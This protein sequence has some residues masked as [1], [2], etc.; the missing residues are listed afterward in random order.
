[1]RNI[2]RIAV[3]V[4]FLA[5]LLCPAAFLAGQSVNARIYGNVQNEEGEYLAGVWVRALNI[6][7]NA[8]TTAFTSAEKGAFRFPALAP[9]VYQVS[10]DM[11]GYQSYVA[12]GIRLTAD[13]SST[14][15]VK[16]KHLKDSDAVLPVSIPPRPQAAPAEQP[17]GRL[18]KWQ[19][20]LSAGTL[21]GEPAELNDFIA[22]DVEIC[23]SKS[24]EYFTAYGL[25]IVNIMGNS[26]V[27]RLKPM[28]GGRPLTARL[29]FFLDRKFSLVLGIGTFEREQVSSYSLSHILVDVKPGSDNFNEEYLLVSEIPDY[30]LGMKGLFPHLGVQ[31]GITLVRGLRMAG[32]VHAGWLFSEFRYASTRLFRDGFLNKISNTEVAMNGRGSGLTLEGGARF[33]A[34]VWRGLGLFAEGLYQMSRVRNVTGER[35]ASLIVQNAE[36]LEVES[37]STEKGEGRW[38]LRDGAAPSPFI[39]SPGDV[40]EYAPFKID[41]SGMGMRAGLFFRF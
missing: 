19:L 40:T 35:N 5:L 27:G 39:P 28:G 9:G 41:L 23:K 16:L 3:L 22:Y 11:E 13:Q 33:E 32:F 36:T 4:F 24:W 18:K 2:S 30:L 25:R 21:F 7:N 17:E 26:S 15:R 14:L 12:S 34:D 6:G 1:M 8:E 10:F 29:R 20:E 31:A 38:V 37:R